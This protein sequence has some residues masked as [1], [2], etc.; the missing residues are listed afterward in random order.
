MGENPTCFTNNPLVSNNLSWPEHATFDFSWLLPERRGT[1]LPEESE[2][3]QE[4]LWQSSVEGTVIV[5][6]AKYAY[7]RPQVGSQNLS[8][9]PSTPPSSNKLYRKVRSSYKWYK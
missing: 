7:L 4:S 1:I 3:R 9:Y 6:T 2:H 5:D 8:L